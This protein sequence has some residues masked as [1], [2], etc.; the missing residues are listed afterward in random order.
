MGEG[1]R[2]RLAKELASLTDRYS[3]ME[4][5][6][7][8][9]G[10]NVVSDLVGRFFVGTMR[11]QSFSSDALDAHQPAC[12]IHGWQLSELLWSS[13]DSRGSQSHVKATFVA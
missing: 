7:Y 6:L 10:R 2:H 12:F 11:G 13:P 8:S 5:M 4:S 9:S 1:D 3:G